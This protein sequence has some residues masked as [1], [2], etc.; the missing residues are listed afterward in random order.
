MGCDQALLELAGE[1][2]LPVMRV[3]QWHPWC[4]SLGYHQEA[5]SIDLEAC[6]ADGVD[7]VRRPTGG[8]AVYHAQELTYAVIIPKESAFYREN[9]T[10]LYTLISEGLASGIRLLGVP[11]ELQKRHVD[12]NA[13]YKKSMSVSCF[14]AAARNEVLVGGKKL[15]GSAQRHLSWGMLQHG[16]ILT[17]REHL[18]LSRY[19]AGN[20][21]RD[22]ERLRAIIDAKTTSLG[23]HLGGDPAAETVADSL[24]KGMETVLGI[25]FADGEMTRA[26]ETR[27][28]ELRER[29]SLLETT[30]AA[31][32]YAR[33][34][35]RHDGYA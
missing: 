23:E 32:A 19:L 7:V 30:A 17:G 25:T 8:R 5:D 1:S 20:T 14:S 31:A 24:R 13:H 10:E 3:Y 11:A 21:T 12:L 27:A 16:S 2:G 4:I 26:E 34:E 9:L 28:G 15:I 33:Q 22:R 18:D 29:F 6:A 35:T